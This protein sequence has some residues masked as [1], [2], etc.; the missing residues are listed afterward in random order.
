MGSPRRIESHLLDGAAGKIEAQLEEPENGPAHEVC[1]VCHPHPLYGGTMHN[2]VVYRIARG[3]RRSGSIVLRFNFRGVG[4]SHG[5]HDH[6]AGEL[7]DARLL[8]EWLRSRYPELPYSAAGFSFGSRIALQLACSIQGT[9]RVIAVGLPTRSS[10]LDYL[11]NCPVYKMFIQS[12]HDEHGPR[13]ELESLYE[14]FAEPKQ[15]YWVEATDHFF[16][17]GL[18]AL[19][20]T[21]YQLKV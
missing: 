6:G 21:I 18:D 9:G 10:E 2:K 11:K 13:T 19:E 12:T 5:V 4:R 8:M 16:L 3:L 15:I 20:E 1:L 17:N 7:E 14:G